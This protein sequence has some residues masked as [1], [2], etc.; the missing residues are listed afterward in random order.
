MVHSSPEIS[1]IPALGDN[2]VWLFPTGAGTV[3]VVDPGQPQPVLAA[4]EERGVRVSHVLL[5]HHHWDHVGGV[6]DLVERDGPEVIGAASD[7]ERLPPLGRAVGDGDRFSLAGATCRV[8]AVPGHTSG[9]VAYVLGDALFAGDTLFSYGCGRM[10]EG[11]PPQMW[12]SLCKLRALP[13]ETRVYCGHE[14]TESNLRFAVHLTPD[15][16]G[17]AA[18]GDRARATRAA[19]RPTVPSRLGDEKAL[20]PFLR[21]DDPNFAVA[22]GATG[23]AP[24]RVFARIRGQKDTF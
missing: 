11:T 18:A 13:D 21:C 15:A 1:P 9:H 22:V 14:Y 5:T 10:F 16:P 17:L 2:Y 3:A 6:E 20:N 7:A 8:L 19:D 23:D 24:E 4:L 12:Q